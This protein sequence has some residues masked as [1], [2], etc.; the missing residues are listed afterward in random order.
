[1]PDEVTIRESFLCVISTEKMTNINTNIYTN[2]NKNTNTIIDSS[3]T[4][5]KLK[6]HFN[7]TRSGDSIV[8]KKC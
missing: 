6:L 2:T 8:Y 5:R 7:N 4:F 1:M 3:K